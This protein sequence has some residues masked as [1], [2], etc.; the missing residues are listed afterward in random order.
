LCEPL[1]NK[2]RE[3]F[4]MK[5]L[6]FALSL[7]CFLQIA[8][9]TGQ[10]QA[11]RTF[12]IENNELKL[13]AP[14]VFETG[15]DRLKPESYEVLAIVKE[16][17]QEKTYISLLRIEGHMDDNGAAV[18]NQ[19]L[20]EKR[21]LAIAR[22]LIEQGIACQRLLAVGFG[23]TKPLA[24]NDSLENRAKNRRMTF[25]NVALRS[26]TIGGLPEDGGGKVAG[27]LCP[28]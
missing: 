19:Q 1:D 24:A 16:Y 23:S 25:V 9:L 22:W 28:K 11:R 27:K 14:V 10:G 6:F 18:K 3:G 12:Q 26:R 15:S 21:A 20:S 7:L 2:I 5:K 17:L 4:L 8:S 13:P